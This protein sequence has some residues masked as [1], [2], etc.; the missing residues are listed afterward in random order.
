MN[1][2]SLQGELND[3]TF[4]SKNFYFGRNVNNDQVVKCFSDIASLARKI[5]RVTG[6][7]EGRTKI[8][9]HIRFDEHNACVVK[10]WVHEPD[11]LFVRAMR[12]KYIDQRPS[13]KKV[14]G[15]Y[16]RYD[17]FNKY[18]SID[19]HPMAMAELNEIDLAII[20][21]YY[22]KSTNGENDYRNLIKFILQND[23][24]GTVIK[25]KFIDQVMSRRYG[26]VPVLP[27]DEIICG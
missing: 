27:K 14:F 25:S 8:P 16:M 22:P 1:V 10:G 2:T 5:G 12:L 6:D 21:H 20:R 11:S 19:A 3:V 17:L 4:L 24:Y 7:V 9:V 13:Y 23:S 18:L 26:M 15:R